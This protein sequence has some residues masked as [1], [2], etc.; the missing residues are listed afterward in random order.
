MTLLSGARR[1]ARRGAR[2]HGPEAGEELHHG[3]HGGTSFDAALVRDGEPAVTAAATVNRYALA[4]PS[5]EI[6]TIGAGGGS[7]GW[8]D[9]GGLLH[10]GRRAPAPTRDRPAM[11]R[12]GRATCTMPT[13]SWATCPRN[14]SRAGASGSTRKLRHAPL[15]SE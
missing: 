3:R 14:I 15:T 13:W 7:I 1:G 11:A 10:M 2:L 8:I 5:M 9:A 4:L 6:N 12:R